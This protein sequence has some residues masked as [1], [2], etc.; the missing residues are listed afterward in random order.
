MNIP[1][2][3]IIDIEGI[4]DRPLNKEQVVAMVAMKEV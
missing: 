4:K 2:N 1:L 3:N